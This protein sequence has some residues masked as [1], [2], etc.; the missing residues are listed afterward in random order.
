MVMQTCNILEALG[1]FLPTIYL[2]SFAKEALDS[3]SLAS[4]FTVIAFNTASV[5][6]CVFMGS[7]I[8]KY[9]VTTCILISTLGATLG[10]F[11]LWGF[12]TSLPLLYVFCVVY[13]LFAGSFSSTWTGI[14]AETQRKMDNADAGLVFAFLAFGRGVGNVAS[15]PLSEALVKGRPWG[16][17]GLAYGTGYGPLITFTGV[18]ALLGGCSFVVRRVGWM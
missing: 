3:S 8:D 12:S 4:A 17:L 15:G 14:I 6:G 2:P 13:G 18:S 1:Y 7:L 9:H 10:V 11:L 16:E 5:F